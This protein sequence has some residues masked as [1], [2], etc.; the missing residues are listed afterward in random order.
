MEFASAELFL[1]ARAL[2][3]VVF[4]ALILYVTFVFFV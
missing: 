1:L 2:N 4:M 3:L